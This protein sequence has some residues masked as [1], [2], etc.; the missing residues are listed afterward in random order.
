MSDTAKIQSLSEDIAFI[1]TMVEEGRR[2]PYRGELSLAAGLIWGT[3]SLYIWAARAGLWIPPGGV[4]AASWAWLAALVVGAAAGVALRDFRRRHTNR[5]AAAAWGA[6]GLAIGV[7]SMAV[8]I[9]AGRTR[10]P[11]IFSLLPP[12]IMALYGGGWLVGAVA[13]GARWQRWIGG[14]CL[15]SSLAL[16]YTAAQPVEYLLFALSLYGLAALPGL[17]AV[18]RPQRNA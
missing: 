9:A 17:V 2:S 3:A 6:V 10:E 13:Y 12:I 16:A 1:R 8:M 5:V 14:L 7:M 15:L 18:L 11:V 4:E